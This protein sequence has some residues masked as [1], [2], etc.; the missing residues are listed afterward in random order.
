[1]GK[2]AMAAPREVLVCSR[3]Q[4]NALA[5]PSIFRRVARRMK[6]SRRSHHRNRSASGRAIKNGA[7]NGC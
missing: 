5:K 3:A 6:S 7:L 2:H 4:T 1:M